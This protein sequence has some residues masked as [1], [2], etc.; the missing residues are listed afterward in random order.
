MATG[1]RL[2]MPQF[3]SKINVYMFV[4]RGR[5]E[6]AKGGGGVVFLCH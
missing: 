5:S 1:R 4:K 3:K 2:E 6:P